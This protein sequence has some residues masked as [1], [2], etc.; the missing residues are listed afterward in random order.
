[1]KDEDGFGV[2]FGTKEAANDRLSGK[3]EELELPKNRPNN[4]R[5]LPVAIKLKKPLELEDVGE[6]NDK[7]EVFAA[8]QDVYPDIS[9]Q[10][11]VDKSKYTLPNGGVDNVSYWNSLPEL[12][13]IKKFLQK[14][15]HDGIVYE[16][17]FEGDGGNSYIVFDPKTSVKSRFSYFSG[18]RVGKAGGGL[19]FSNIATQGSEGETNPDGT[20]KTNASSPVVPLVADNFEPGGG[21][22]EG[23][24]G[25]GPGNDSST[26]SQAGG[27]SRD[28]NNADST[29]TTGGNAEKRGG[30]V[31][32]MQESEHNVIK[33][34]L[35]LSNHGSPLSD[36]MRIARQHRGRP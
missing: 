25:G 7:R 23:G 36:A 17:Q 35:T 6:W 34:A 32:K 21:G 16:N 22:G 1:M 19:S 33:R 12:P 31:S 29:G 3:K 15:G 9:K 13:E 27:G 30:R 10:F 14:K 18:G 11:G 20:P 24:K 5:I 2:H 26:G 28:S 4:D 8:V